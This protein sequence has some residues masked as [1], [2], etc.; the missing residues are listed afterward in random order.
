MFLYS[1][2]AD[3]QQSIVLPIHYRYHAP[4]NTSFVPVTIDFPEMFLEIADGDEITEADAIETFMCDDLRY[5]CRWKRV[6]YDV[7]GCRL[8]A[9]K[10]NSIFIC[11]LLQN[12]SRK[13]LTANIP[14]GNT[15]VSGIITVCTILLSW[16][17]ALSL[18]IVI[19]NKRN[20]K[21]MTKNSNK[22]N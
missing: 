16:I 3:G 13:S 6:D 15:N 7:S 10:E 12:Y 4:G 22:T 14:I 1:R 9:P 5:R 2:T 19:N 11:Y 18:F 20:R 21:S 17:A 8:I